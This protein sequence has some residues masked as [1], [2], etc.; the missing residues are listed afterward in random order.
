MYNI[1]SGARGTLTQ[2]DILAGG[3]VAVEISPRV[4]AT[5][6]YAC[7]RLSQI[8]VDGTT[9][10]GFIHCVLIWAAGCALFWACSLESVSADALLLGGVVLSIC[11]TEVD[12]V[13]VCPGASSETLRAHSID[14]SEVALAFTGVGIDL[15]G[16]GWTL[17][18]H[19]AALSR[20][21]VPFSAHTLFPV[22]VP[23][24]VAAA[25]LTSPSAIPTAVVSDWDAEA[26]G[27]GGEAR[28]TYAYSI[29]G[30]S[31]ARADNARGVCWAGGAGGWCWE[32]GD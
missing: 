32:G 20:P 29:K 12:A 3:R 4:E 6:T 7:L 21:P 17:H 30:V 10:T 11:F 19:C 28:H 5:L 22:G 9:H 1:E 2:A 15:Y 23:E 24:A 26:G 27:V 18:A 8:R 16:V 31:I 14:Q 13:V 25:V